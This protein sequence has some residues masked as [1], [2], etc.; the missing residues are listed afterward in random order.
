MRLHN[1][2]NFQAKVV[3]EVRGFILISV[4]KGYDGCH[5]AAGRLAFSLRKEKICLEN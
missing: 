5:I 1:D 4:R 3:L 2:N